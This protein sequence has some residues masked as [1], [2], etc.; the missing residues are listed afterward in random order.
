MTEMVLG[1]VADSSSCGGAR[2]RGFGRP[3]APSIGESPAIPVLQDRIVPAAS[4]ARGLPHCHRGSECVASGAR[5]DAEEPIL[6][7]RNQ[8]AFRSTSRLRETAPALAASGAKRRPFDRIGSDPES[9]IQFALIVRRSGRFV[10]AGRQIV[11]SISAK[12]K[13]PM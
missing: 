9:Q 7:R 2:R 10:I 3:T 12:S 6:M 4:S 11:H 13:P 1:A 8:A 5:R